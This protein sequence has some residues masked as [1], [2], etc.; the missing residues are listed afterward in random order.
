MS[1]SDTFDYDGRIDTLA[2]GL[3]DDLPEHPEDRRRQDINQRVETTADGA[4]MVFKNGLALRVLAEADTEPDNWNHAS[5]YDSLR[6]AAPS[7]AYSVVRQ[8][9]R[10]AVDE[11]LD[12][13]R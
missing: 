1:D 10:A 6:D 7:L 11:R 12:A 2:D 4:E 3:V 8:D 13:D 5:E 9:L